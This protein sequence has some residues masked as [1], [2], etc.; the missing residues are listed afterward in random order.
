M[1]VL[2]TSLK[3]FLATMPGVVGSSVT[4]KATATVQNIATASAVVA[5]SA[6]K[7]ARVVEAAAAAAAEQGSGDGVSAKSVWVPKL[8]PQINVSERGVY[9]MFGTSPCQ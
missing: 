1:N 4:V 5:A 3:G 8:P 2:E 7:T 6:A 9:A